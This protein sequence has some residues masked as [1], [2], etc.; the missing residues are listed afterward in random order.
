[1]KI[2]YVTTVSLTLN[3]FLIPHIEYLKQKGYEIQT[4]SN[5]DQQL[6]GEFSKLG[7]KHNKIDFSRNPFSISNI[8]AY[9]EIKELC[10]REKFDVVHVHTP[11]AA[12]VTRMAL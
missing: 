2:L 12:F 6:S 10:N 11:V 3:S 7:I 4:A 8:K 9:K 5:I 1:M